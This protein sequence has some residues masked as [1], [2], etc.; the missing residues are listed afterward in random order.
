MHPQIPG[1]Q[2]ITQYLL[3][4]LSSEETERLDE[5]SLTDD[6]FATR[7]RVVEDELVDAYVGGELTGQTLQ[8]FNSFYLAS[9]RR[10][11]KVR[12]AQVFR[13][14]AEQH[15]LTGAESA[16]SGVTARPISQGAGSHR[17]RRLEL[18]PSSGRAWQ[19]GLAA[20][21]SLLLAATAWLATENWR[22]RDQVNQA[23][24][25]QTAAEQ[26]ERELL[27]RQRSFT[28]EKEVEV[29]RLRENLDRVKRESTAL[30]SQTLWQFPAIVAVA[31]T[32]QTRGVS[33]IADVNVPADTD[34]VA[35]E[36]QLESGDYP[37][38]LATLKAVSDNQVIWRS[39]RLKSRT[40][41]DIRAVGISLRPALLKS[42]RYMVEVVGISA[43]GSNE[44][45]GS[46]VFRVIKSD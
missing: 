23:R 15:A 9:P 11:G 4:S 40:S 8:Q 41:G 32:P 37:G 30:P 10:R 22:L 31:L 33:P 27:A 2:L 19:W 24:T 42:S 46:Y 17:A 38:Y 36:L 7:L 20:A 14:V 3:G 1:D 5:L 29:A 13:T 28:S 18:L 34:F 6:E 35:I 25:E 44:S 39:G 26:R 16:Q 21:A 12:F 43:G 45:V